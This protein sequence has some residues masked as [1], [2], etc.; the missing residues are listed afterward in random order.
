AAK[1]FDRT[2]VKCDIADPAPIS[3]SK[4]A[5]DHHQRKQHRVPIGDVHRME[6]DRPQQA[7]KV[8]RGITSDV[9]H[10]QVVPRQHPLVSRQIENEP[11]VPGQTAV[12]LL[13]CTKF[14]HPFMAQ[15]ISAEDN[16]KNSIAE[17][18]VVD[19]ARTYRPGAL[20]CRTGTSPEIEIQPDYRSA[21]IDLR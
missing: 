3:R 5:R 12:E 1:H 9:A 18:Q 13:Q 17:W 15:D 21:A 4:L 6:P 7:A 16:A 2:R 19:R 14:V 8:R 20:D 10:P 11:A